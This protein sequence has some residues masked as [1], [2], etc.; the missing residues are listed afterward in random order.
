M[1]NKLTTTIHILLTWI[2]SISNW[3]K[4]KTKPQ[5]TQQQ[6]PPPPPPSPPIPNKNNQMKPKKS[7]ENKY[8]NDPRLL[9]L[10]D[11][12]AVISVT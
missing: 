4:T 12:L 2:K 6:D 11:F 5:S 3:E 9:Y 10:Q 7:K 1:I 8:S